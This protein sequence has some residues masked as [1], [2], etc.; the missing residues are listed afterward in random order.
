M[1]KKKE[2]QALRFELQA[3]KNTINAL[4]DRHEL[5]SVGGQEQ[6]S[7]IE[8]LRAE[9]NLL[10]YG[11]MIAASRLFVFQEDYKDVDHFAA[12]LFEEIREKYNEGTFA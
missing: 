8:E 6:K 2:I 12:D 4:K 9:R 10:T 7:I 11:F 5:L 1:S 3:A